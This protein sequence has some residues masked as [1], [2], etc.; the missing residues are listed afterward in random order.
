MAHGGIRYDNNMHDVLCG[1]QCG[2]NIVCGSGNNVHTGIDNMRNVHTDEYTG[3][4]YNAHVAHNRYSV[5]PDF[6]V[7]CVGNDDGIQRVGSG[8]A[9]N[10]VSGRHRDVMLTPSPQSSQ[11]IKRQGQTWGS[12]RG[13]QMSVSGDRQAD[14][15]WAPCDTSIVSKDASNQK[16]RGRHIVSAII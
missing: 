8:I 14:P 11:S 1:K 16:E 7:D 5:L 12:V 10:G 4:Q 2:S 9:C 13:R 3:I 6:D 15:A